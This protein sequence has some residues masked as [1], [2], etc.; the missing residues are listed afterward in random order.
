M[1]SSVFQIELSFIILTQPS[2]KASE[3]TNKRRNL[4]ETKNVLFER[5]DWFYFEN[6]I[7]RTKD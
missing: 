2:L 7:K 1:T 6:L 5:M 4:K 3:S